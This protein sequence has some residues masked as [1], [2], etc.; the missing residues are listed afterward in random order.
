MRKARGQSVILAGV[1]VLLLAVIAAATVGA[2]HIAP[3][4]VLQILLAR[5]PGVHLVPTWESVQATILWDIRFPRV[6]L[7]LIAGVALSV[8]G[9]AYQGL[10]KNPMADP[11]V[12]GV[13]PGAALGASI[14]YAFGDRLPLPPVASVPVLAFVTGL[15][16]IALVY[17]LAAVGRRVPVTGILLAGVAVGS[18]CM[19]LVSLIIWIARPDARESIIFWMMGGL[20][21]ATW[22]KVG[23]LL[24]YVIPG[25]SVMVYYGRELN[26]LLLGEDAAQ[27]LG[28]EVEQ[29]K[30]AVVAAGALLTAATV[31]FCGAIGFIGMIVPH[32]MRFLVGPDH[33][34]L[35]PASAVGGAVLLILADTAART[36]A[37]PTEIPVGLVL[38]LL[39]GPFFL[40]LLRRKL[41]PADA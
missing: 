33:R 14:M 35:L 25:L 41:K 26:A 27:H 3:A 13:S 32:L 4:D 12:L 7:A 11:Y 34:L 1:G 15:A 24:A 18:L 17:R 31:A 40:W 10:L 2:V 20:S 19:A 29:V 8:A 9:T 30:R 28:V 23:W 5:L 6:M 21:G 16:V 36:L 37:S 38:S 39:G 22:A